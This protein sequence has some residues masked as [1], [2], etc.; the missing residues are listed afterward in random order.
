MKLCHHRYRNYIS[1]TI[2]GALNSLVPECRFPPHLLHAC[3]EI[4]LWLAGTWTELHRILSSWCQSRLLFWNPWV[5]T[6]FSLS[7]SVLLVFFQVRSENQSRPSLS[8]LHTDVH[9]ELWPAAQLDPRWHH[10]R[11]VWQ[12]HLHFS[13]SG[14]S[15]FACLVWNCQIS[16]TNSEV[17]PET[18][19]QQNI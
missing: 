7:T 9:S 12:D 8:A 5:L 13:T 19:A 16:W 3:T 17:T 1:L 4:K 11:R 18:I 10:R 14:T 15:S 2:K 6:G